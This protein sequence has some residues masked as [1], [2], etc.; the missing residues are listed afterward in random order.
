MHVCM[1]AC[2]YVRMYGCVYVFVCVCV[3]VCVYIYIIHTHTHTLTNIY[4]CMHTGIDSIT[5][6]SHVG[7]GTLLTVPPLLV[8]TIFLFPKLYSAPRRHIDMDAL[9]IK[10]QIKDQCVL[11]LAGVTL[12]GAVLM[13]FLSPGGYMY[14][15]MYLCMYSCMYVI[16]YL[17]THKLTRIIYVNNV[18]MN[19]YA[20]VC[21]Y[22]CMYVC[23]C[24]FY[25]YI[26]SRA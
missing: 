19:F 16:V 12:A 7:M 9:L 6:I 17:Y 15:C 5:F 26:S 23:D 24:V 21:M 4:T 18:H 13:M 3:C 11:R 10:Y 22:V 2:M 20:Y 14:V 8:S 25:T 1:Y